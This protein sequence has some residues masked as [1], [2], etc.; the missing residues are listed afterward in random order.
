MGRRLVCATVCASMLLG[1]SR[2]VPAQNQARARITAQ[3]ACEIGIGAY[4]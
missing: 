1:F 3:E 2:A 4:V